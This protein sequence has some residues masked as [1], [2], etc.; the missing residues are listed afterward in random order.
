MVA[1]AV[2][3][4]TLVFLALLFGLSREFVFLTPW[5][6]L[7][8]HSYLRGIVLYAALLFANILGLTIWI[9]RKFFLRDTGRK[10]K[11]FDQEIHS[12]HSELSEEIA[13]QF[14]EE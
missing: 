4:S 13:A 3:I 11:H 1:N 6:L 5:R 12:G 10:L 9:E 8:L 7:I 14:G 2:F